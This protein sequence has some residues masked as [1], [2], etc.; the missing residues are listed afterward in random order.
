TTIQYQMIESLLNSG[1]PPAK[2]VYI[3]MDHPML[4]L[5]VFS[6]ILDC[7]HEHIYA[8]KDCYYFF[9]EVQYAQDW[10]QWLKTVYDTQPDTK[11]VA[12]G[13]ASPA[14]M[15]GTHES[16]AGRWSVIQAPTM[17]FYEYCELIGVEKPDL[18]PAVNITSLLSQSQQERTQVMLQLSKAHNHFS[19]Y[20]QVGG[21]PEL[22][23]ADNDLAARQIL[24]EDVVDK[25]LKGD[26][27]SLYPIRNSTELE[28]IF[29]YLCN[30]S[31]SIV[32][33]E[34]IAK[35]LQGVSRPT[36]E[37]YIRYLESANLIY[38]SW[39]IDMAG[40]KV[41]KASPKIYIADAALRNA[42]LMDD[43]IPADP[44]EM[45]KVVE[46]A[47]YAHV[48]AFYRHKATSVGYYRG[49]RKNKE[50]D[51]VVEYANRGN[52]LVEVKYREGAPV[53]DGDAI[54][55]LCKEADAAIIVTKNANDYGIHTTASGD[56]LL[57]IPAFAFLYLLGHAE[58]SGD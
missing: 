6:D 41:L 55:R 29:L 35:E 28:R 58:K 31:S 32:S 33:I 14:L 10:D 17:S 18:P 13:S 9:D 46:T 7:Y 38:Q 1:V 30:V 8:G 56:K 26:L 36:V 45:G 34:A 2:I 44:V 23:A 42:V 24:R 20:L 53:S 49:G 11:V 52:I 50:V 16:G 5:S 21:F 40:K 27:P 43:S 4:K 12:T 15:K 39:P 48:A 37:N 3:S 54:C 47:V 22:A 19:R 51:V 25:V 57:R